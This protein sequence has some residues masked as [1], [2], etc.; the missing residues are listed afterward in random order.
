MKYIFPIL[1]FT[2]CFFLF[3][4]TLFAQKAFPVEH[5]KFLKEF[6]NYLSY[7]GE[8]REKGK[9]IEK[10][11]EAFWESDS[12]LPE[13]KDDF[14]NTATKLRIKGGKSYPEFVF[15]TAN[16]MAFSRK[17]IP[18]DQ[19]KLYE[20]E[21]L[22]LL[23][24]KR[25][26][27]KKFN[28]ILVNTYQLVAKN[29]VYSS[30]RALWKISTDDYSF[31]KENN[32]LSIH[33]NNTD[34]SCYYGNDSIKIYKTTGVVNPWTH[35]WK[36]NGGKVG[37]ERVGISNDTIYAQLRNYNI[38]LRGAKYIADSVIFINSIYFNEPL[39]GQLVDN[40]VN[41]DNPSRS[42]YPRFRS[43][44]QKFYIK[45]IV[46]GIDYEG[47]FSMRGKHFIGSGKD[48]TPAKLTI[49]K[50]DTIK[51]DAYSEAFKLDN[52]SI[53]SEKTEIIL[54]LSED[55]IY[56][57]NLTF[58]Y[59]IK[60]Q[61]LELLRTKEGMSK[62]DYINS[63]H[64]IKMDFT[65]FK[66]AI[67]KYTIE[68]TMIQTADYP[69]EVFFESMDYYQEKRY[70]DIKM[71][72]QR[73]P[74]EILVDFVAYWGAPDFFANDLAAYIKFSPNQVKQML[75]RVAYQGFILY[76][77]D[78]E[79]VVVKPEVWDF[80]DNHKGTR[81]SDV[82]QFYSKTKSKKTN[83]ELSLLNYNL[84]M[85]GVPIVHVSDSQNVKIY[86]LNNKLTIQK[87]R[88]F[89]FNGTVQA[90][91]F[92]YYGSDFRF[93][94][95]NFMIDLNQC[96]SMKM[97]AETGGYDAIGKKK[98][99]IVQTKMENIN[100]EFYIDD[101]QNKSGRKNHEE[102]PKFISKRK[103]YVYYDRK[104]NYNGV[105]NKT[106][107]YF[108]VNPFSIDSISGF[109]K[110]NLEFKG[111]LVSAG[112]FPDIEETLVLRNDFSLG[113]QKETDQN[114]LPLYDGR[115]NYT[116]LIDLSNEGLRGKGKIEYLTSTT[117]SDY[118]IFFPDSLQGHANKF[119][120]WKQKSPV[121]FPSVV[122]VDD[123][124]KW[125]VK[126]DKFL[127]YQETTSFKMF[128]DQAI[129]KGY[130]NLTSHGLEGAGEMTIQRSMVQSNKF[131]YK[132]DI[133]DADTSNFNLYTESKLNIDFK[134]ENVNTHIDFTERKGVFRSNGEHTT[135]EFPKN[136]YI[137]IMD[138]LTWYMD[139]PELEISASDNVLEKF[140]RDKE[141]M[142][143]AELEELFLNGP[144]FI[145]IHPDQDR[146]SFVAP[147]AR[148][149][150]VDHIIYAEDVPFIRVADATIF[151]S[152]G[153]V[154]IEKNAVIRTLKKAKIIANLTTRH[155]TFYDANINITGRYKYSGLGYYDFIDKAGRKQKIYFDKIGVDMTN[156]TIASGRIAE[157]NRF[158][159]NPNFW[160]QGKVLIEA[161]R[162]NL[163]FKG[164]VKIKT[165]CDSLHSKWL[166][167]S[168]II[169]PQDIFIPVDSMSRE[170]NNQP[171]L[172]G[173]SLSNYGK[174]YP[175]FLSKFSENFDYP[176]FETHGQL[177]YDYD[178]KS[179]MI[180]SRDKIEETNLPGNY[181]ELHDDC[182]IYGEG[183]FFF[184]DR[185]GQFHPNTI[186]Y[187]EYTPEKDTI[188]FFV[189]MLMDVYFNQQAW[190]RM[191]DVINGTPGLMG[192]DLSDREYQK[193]LVEY[194]GI[195]KA[196]K[197]F[198]QLSLGNTKKYPKE[199]E[200]L[201]VLSG[202]NLQ[203]HGYQSVFFHEGPI[204]I[205]N[206]GKHQI[207]KYVYGFIMIEVNRRKASFEI[208]LEVDRDTYFYFKYSG[209]LLSAYSSDAEFNQ[210]VMET[211]ASN[212][213]LKSTNK[214]NNYSF[215]ISSPSMIDRFKKE[216]K[217]KFNIVILPKK[218]KDEEE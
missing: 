75:L 45:D 102:Y 217:R 152:D 34:L 51:L 80:I 17:G 64:K 88:S 71:H 99:A 107:F 154:T 92:Y 104:S 119:T 160:Y 131:T 142:S 97:V 36:G 125:H 61:L 53:F 66:W 40:A 121:E 166:K 55:S 4:T 148:Y 155:H 90:G 184:S 128:A 212:T 135:W 197:W 178:E 65:W 16:I 3:P 2:I 170:I 46:E 19:Y 199:L 139:K 62:V 52:N 191:A 12:L 202:I 206:A 76:D 11:F 35:S 218:D 210:I 116:N 9:S 22:S 68:F 207:N 173:L 192:I 124:I 120:I 79:Y 48:D 182:S 137:S 112:I 186:G 185:F 32:F 10:E 105:Y 213:T 114:G 100:G 84:K 111:T 23:K 147:K 81:D 30:P 72:D 39:L 195:E 56:H 108:E 150:Y 138:E 63:Y 106:S 129:H 25:L 180:G 204:G 141:N 5:N 50:N 26:K 190:K 103:S 145:S 115:A 98:L 67:D 209:G 29:I 27:T 133:I 153:H 158:K 171:I 91:Q 94:Y 7:S 47:G 15:Y 167:F 130:L 181:M 123:D 177:Y 70:S 77:P 172:T 13:H 58:K 8:I 38:D 85:E 149:N 196:D 205:A 200:R 96:D 54:K 193:S 215:R 33:V 183:K 176:I 136:K 110:E 69:N 28:E 132:Q 134:S 59:S 89:L 151:T 6:S 174:L 86:P 169:N 211:K 156:Q 144:K 101:P 122:G 168:A 163:E 117:E 162:E 49:T 43:Y 208:F 187:F 140:E 189:N 18:W 20:A 161:S 203:W 165:E 146:L 14:I 87:N 95:E 164:A 24:A 113:F 42:S 60:A 78:K 214:S 143:P 57:P 126:D 216:L 37:W 188:D 198:S 159:L 1:F 118:L 74:L 194:L 179:Y 93:D 109:S 127:V 21:L 73:N 44:L 157:P 82:I 175:A 83:A 201:L 41:L 31:F